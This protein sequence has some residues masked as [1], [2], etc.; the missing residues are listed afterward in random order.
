M[1]RLMHAQMHKKVSSIRSTERNLCRCI[2]TNINISSIRETGMCAVCV[3]PSPQSQLNCMRLVCNRINGTFIEVYC[4][5]SFLFSPIHSSTFTTFYYC[6]ICMAAIMFRMLSILLY[7][8][9]CPRIVH[10]DRRAL[11]WR[12]CIKVL[13]MHTETV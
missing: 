5:A 4:F 1:L 12:K 6:C 10:S 9:L 2:R 11:K 13:E 8:I 7:Q 3:A